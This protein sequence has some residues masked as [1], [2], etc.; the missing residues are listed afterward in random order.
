MEDLRFEI[1]KS[2][3]HTFIEFLCKKINEEA[4]EDYGK[5]YNFSIIIYNNTQEVIGGCNG[6]IVFGSIYTDQIWV[7]PSHRNKGLGHNLMEKIHEFGRQNNCKLSTVTTMS[8]QVPNFYKKLGY[9]VDFIREGYQKKSS[10]IFMSK[11]L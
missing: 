3:S 11:Q 6:S 10:C 4:Q 2:P 8:F 1:S 7:E 5:A 9:K